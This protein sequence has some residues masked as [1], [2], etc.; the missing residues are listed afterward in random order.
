MCYNN[1][2]VEKQQERK[3]IMTALLGMLNSKIVGSVVAQEMLLGSGGWS[4]FRTKLEE[5]FLHGLGGEGAA[6]IGIAI[7]VM[8]IVG[9]VVSFFLHRANPQ[10]R[11]PGWVTML[12]A[13][14]AGAMIIG[15]VEKPLELL[16]EAGNWAYEL[17]G[18]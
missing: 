2:K 4:G 1:T 10:T 16:K 8:G 9:A 17:L 6:G 15:G 5:W 18:L 3:H 7:A 14:V 11:F 12:L 13:G